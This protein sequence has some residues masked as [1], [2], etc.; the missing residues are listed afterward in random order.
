[1]DDKHVPI[2]LYF[3][4]Q[5]SWCFWFWYFDIFPKNPILALKA[6]KYTYNIMLIKITPEKT[7]NYW[8]STFEEFC[9]KGGVE[10]IKFIV[11]SVSVPLR[12]NSDQFILDYFIRQFSSTFSFTELNERIPLFVSFIL[13][14]QKLLFMYFVNV[15]R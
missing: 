3:S 15:E 6:P 5:Y 8:G 14:L 4:F 12:P 1:M 2:K 10:W 13:I 9:D 7:Q 11:I